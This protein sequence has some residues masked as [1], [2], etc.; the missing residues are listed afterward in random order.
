MDN[1]QGNINYQQ[2]LRD[3]RKSKYTNNHGQKLSKAIPQRK[4]A[5]PRHINEQLLSNFHRINH[6]YTIKAVRKQRKKQ[7]FHYFVKP[8]SYRDCTT[9]KLWLSSIYKYRCKMPK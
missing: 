3:G 6:S 7:T 1:T 8:K 4:S 2:G 5:E 9:E